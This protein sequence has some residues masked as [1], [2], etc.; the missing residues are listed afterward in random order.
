M[1]Q[2]EQGA[3]AALHTF[4]SAPELLIAPER[5]SALPTPLP[6]AVHRAALVRIAQAYATAH[7]TASAG[8]ARATAPGLPAPDEVALLL[9]VQISD[10]PVA[11]VA[12]AL[13]ATHPTKST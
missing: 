7:G 12:R 13:A 5:L 10:A 6:G 11:L 8:A 9:D 3:E 2:G 1:L 4:L